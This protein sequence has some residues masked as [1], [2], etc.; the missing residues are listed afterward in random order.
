VVVSVQVVVSVRAAAPAPVVVPVRAAA[1]APVVVPV[2][3]AAREDVRSSETSCRAQPS[4]AEYA[5]HDVQVHT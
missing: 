1:P 2:R 4:R 3:A 5:R